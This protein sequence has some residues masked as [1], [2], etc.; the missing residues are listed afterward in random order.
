MT[1]D[2]TKALTTAM[3]MVKRYGAADAQER[4]TAETS[5]AAQS[6]DDAAYV[7]WRH[8]VED[9]ADLRIRQEAKGRALG[10][11]LGKH[12]RS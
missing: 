7:F 9:I 10:R 4:A 12:E 3:E 1:A 11:A 6:G 8:V 5:R 2:R